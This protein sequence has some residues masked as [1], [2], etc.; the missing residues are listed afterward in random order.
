MNTCGPGITDRMQIPIRTIAVGLLFAFGAAAVSA[1]TKVPEA[2]P[3]ISSAATQPSTPLDLS[4]HPPATQPSAPLDLS[5]HPAATEPSTP[6]DL[7]VHPAT[8]QPPTPLDLATQP[9]VA[10][11][12]APIDPLQSAS[13]EVKRVARWVVDSHDNAGLPF[14]L[15]DKVNAQVLAFSGAG[16]LRGTAPVL[17]GMAH[18]DRMLVPNTAKMSQMPPQVRITPAGRF[19]SRLAIDSHGK[20]ILVL[21]YEASFSLHAVVKGTPAEHRAERLNSPTS[22]DNRIS[23]GCIN[24]PTAFYMTVVSPS[25]TNTKGVVYVLPETSPASQLFGFQ[26]FDAPAAGAQQS[27]TALNAQAAQTIQAPSAN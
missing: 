19:V 3:P 2:T 12:L 1:Q 6:I 9:A 23:F 21:D 27:T 11:Q 17:L 15:I 4:L 20:E 7:A 10:A 8:T 16:Q 18:G 25:F 24:V 5:L 13:A 14:L 22:Q 26:P